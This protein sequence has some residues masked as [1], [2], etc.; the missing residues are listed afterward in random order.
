MRHLY[1]TYQLLVVAPVM[2]VATALAS[3]VTIVGCAVGLA[4]FFSYYPG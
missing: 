4:H 1:R 3:L 2:V